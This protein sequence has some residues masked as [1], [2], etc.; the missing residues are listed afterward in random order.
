MSVERIDIGLQEIP[1]RITEIIE[2]VRNCLT[3]DIV[4]HTDVKGVPTIK[5]TIEE[6]VIP[7]S[8]EWK[9]DPDF[10]KRVMS[11]SPGVIQTEKI[12]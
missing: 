8:D 11:A 1:K 7:S 9:I 3:L 5:Y 2:N 4:V 6:A 10:A 12:F